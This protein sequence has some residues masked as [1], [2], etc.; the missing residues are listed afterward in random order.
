MQYLCKLNQEKHIRVSA[1]GK[2][3]YSVIREGPA[4]K[5]NEFHCH[6]LF[7]VKLEIRLK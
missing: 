4:S 2:L 7:K 6:G 5:Q 1:L 3:Q